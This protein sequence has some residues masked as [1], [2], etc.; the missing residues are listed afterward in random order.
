M[1]ITAFLI[2][3]PRPVHHLLAYWLGLMVTGLGAALVALFLL[4]D[5]MV[6]VTHWVD[7]IATSPLVPPIQIII[8]VL[9][10]GAAAMLG[11]RTP[12][13]QLAN[14]PM[15]ASE[16]SPAAPEPKPTKPRTLL[17]RLSWPAL[18]EG[19]SSGMAFVAGLCTSTQ[20]VEYWGAMLAILASGAAAATQVAAALVFTLVAYAIVEIPLISHLAAPAKTQFV[21]GQMQVW[22]RERRRVVFACIFG[23]AGVLLI[24]SGLGNI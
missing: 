22:L 24:A 8:G 16:P 11:A 14:A 6:P 2:S 10:L 12:V 23:V 15:A 9:A 4:R 5:L 17:S 3:C 1:G 20:I 13:P 7:S 21:L 18:L 19:R